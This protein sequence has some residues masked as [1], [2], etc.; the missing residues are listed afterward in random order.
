VACRGRPWK[1]TNKL[2]F[3][4]PETR[5]SVELR[6]IHP[7][8]KHEVLL[9]DGGVISDGEKKGIFGPELKP[10]PDFRHK[11]RHTEKHESESQIPG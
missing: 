10:V 5:V 6:R 9:N 2:L 4:F 3:D 1:Q 7:R 11:T 8:E